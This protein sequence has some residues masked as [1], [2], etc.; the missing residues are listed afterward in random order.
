MLLHS[1][2]ATMH[3]AILG[4]EPYYSSDLAITSAGT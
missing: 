4:L 1:G 2:K 3:R